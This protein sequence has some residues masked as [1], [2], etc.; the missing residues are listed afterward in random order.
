MPRKKGSIR[1]REPHL[2]VDR[3]SYLK[4]AGIAAGS[5]GLL[6][7][8]ASA[9]VTHRGIQFNTTI[10]MVEDMGCDPSGNEPCD[11][12]ITEAA[13]DYTLLKF[14]A[15]EYKITEK[16]A[17]LGMT[18]VG[19]LGEGDARFVV[20]E[21]FNEK[22]LVI[23]RGTGVLFEG[24]DIDQQADGATPALHIA[25]DDNIRVHDVELIGQGIH[26]D[27]IPKDQPGYSPGT[28]GENGNPRVHDFFYPIVRSET[29]TGLVTELSA[30]N[31][32]LMGTYNAGNGRSG[33]WVGLGT[34]GTITFRDCR[35]EE[36][37]SN[38]CYTSRTYG[39]VQYEGG[40]YR[41]NDNNQIRLGSENSYVDGATIEVDADASEAPNPDEAL[42]YRGV[43]IE[44]GHNY[45]PVD[46]SIRNCEI[47]IRS[48]PRTGGA[49]VAEST[50]GHFEV[51]N[52]RIG[53]DTDGVRAVLGKEPDGG[54]Y[55]PPEKPHS[56]ILRNVSVT[57][58]ATDKEAIKLIDRPDS[59][60]DGC[61]IE[62][63]GANRDGI[64]VTDS[65]ETAIHDTVLDVTG[66]PVTR[67]G[68][69]GV[70]D[71]SVEDISSVDTPSGDTDSEQTT[72]GPGLRWSSSGEL[73]IEA[74]Q[75]GE[76]SYRLAAG[77]DLQRSPANDASV[78]STDD[79]S[80]N[81]VS[82]QVGEGGIDS[83]TFTGGILAFEMS[84]DATLTLNGQEITAD[85]L[86]NNTIT[87]A[88]DGGKSTYDLAVSV[89][90]GKSDAMNATVDDNDDL[91]DAHATGQVDGGGRDSYGFSGE[92][93]AFDLDG[94]ATV[95]VNDEEVSAD[96]FPD[97]TLTI[98]SNGEQATYEF[99]VDGDVEKSSRNGATADDNDDISG[100]TVSGQV[101]G[102]GRD[103]YSISGSVAD[104]DLNG[105]ATIHLNDR[106][107]SP[108]QVT[109][110]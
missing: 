105:D 49:I 74:P 55:D 19:F 41:N 70:D 11:N 22:V 5:A 93:I 27:S 87:V 34:Y 44:M 29:G 104:F 23:D 101:D 12:Q 30:N 76:A 38:G 8:L 71:F 9:A 35:I 99:T 1:G 69:A 25:G 60:V 21:N 10:D 20:P 6:S 54:S 4:F 33:I 15:G 96:S 81:T 28:G 84:G 95:Y 85:Q 16:N 77:D 83:Y 53:V 102:G 32:G 63:T 88:S 31:H 82:G 47:P 48:A 66:T 68:S 45:T 61:Q 3:R 57:G 43:R 36:F 17:L 42:N 103:S 75:N 80:G 86:P 94:D 79:R 58:D 7:G 65:S 106:E 67:E 72:D 13:D 98:S 37:G 50:A 24:I 39:V 89:T 46:V 109:N 78:D 91:S 110:K 14:P 92:I 52:T 26:P 40:V 100:N 107:V 2:S 108:S 59:V 97:S 18:N 90:V 64:L 73:T 62:Q 56:A 51:E